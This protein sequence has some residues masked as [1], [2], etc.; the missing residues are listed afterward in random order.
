MV[1]T[2][3]KFHQKLENTLVFK[4]GKALYK[5]NMHHYYLKSRFKFIFFWNIPI[6]YIILFP[7]FVRSKICKF[8]LVKNENWFK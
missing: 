2:D 6:Y 3:I 5:E 1:K 8:F 7:L 4:M